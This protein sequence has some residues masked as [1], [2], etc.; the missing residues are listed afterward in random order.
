MVASGAALLGVLVAG[1]TRLGHAQAPAPAEKASA[2]QAPAAPARPHKSVYGKLERVDVTLNGVIMRSN[3]DKRLAWKF[4]HPVVAELDK[5]KPGDPMIVIYRQ[6]SKNEKRVTA[7][8]FPGT[9]E[10]PTYINLTGLRVT[11]R[12]GPKVDGVCGR[13]GAGPVTES[14]IPVGGMGEAVDECWCCAVAGESCTPGNKSGNGKAI[15]V[16]CF[17]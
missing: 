14:L 4:D 8:A 12:S 15:L 10:R 7:V 11:L 9:A 5:F 17:K 13:E 1:S 2:D 16:H 6:I 3:E